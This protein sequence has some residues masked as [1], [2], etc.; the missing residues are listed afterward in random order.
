[1]KIFVVILIFITQY[2]LYRIIFPKQKDVTKDND[3]SQSRK[4]DGA[5]VIGKSRYVLPER[6]KPAQTPA[7]DSKTEEG[8]EKANIFAPGNEN[9]DA[10]IPPE[11]LDEVFGEEP[12]PE[13]LDIPPDEDEETDEADL[14]EENEDLRQSIGIERDMELAEGL[15]IEEMTEVAE[16][17]NHPSPSNAGLL[18]KVEKTDVFEKLVSGDMGKADRIKAVIDRHIRSRYPEAGNEESDKEWKDFD[19]RN[20][21]SKTSKK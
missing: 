17:I 2:L 4:T 16:A 9:R 10:V 6:R 19:I 3:A 14:E 13:D 18:L 12:R 5:D 11:D 7:T 1:M 20:F 21:L 8:Q 15:S